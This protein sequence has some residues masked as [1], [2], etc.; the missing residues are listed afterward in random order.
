M[1]ESAGDAWSASFAKYNLGEILADRGRLDEAEP[2]LRRALRV[3]RASRAGP[4]AAEAMRQLGRVLARKQEF[5]EALALLEAARQDQIKYGELA[6]VLVT[7]AR[8]AECLAIEGRAEESLEL[9]D[10]LLAEAGPVEG[11]AASLALLQR[12]R[13]WSLLLLGR[14][15]E[16]RR[17][18]DDALRSA[19]ERGADYEVAL[20]LGLLAAGPDL[21]GLD[22]DDLE[23]ERAEILE[24][25][26]V[27]VSAGP[28]ML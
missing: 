3:W 22:V 17:A 23:R 12:V 9:A 20:A 1:W 14:Q 16:A 21:A 6:E 24:R 10:R 15:A 18:V 2:L 4:E 13:G 26:G 19:R 25:L 11:S 7:G 28:P 5:D 27:Q 8:I